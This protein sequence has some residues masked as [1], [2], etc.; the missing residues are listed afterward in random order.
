[1]LEPL[2]IRHLRYFLA[3]AESENFTRAAERLR[4][5]Q[6]NVSQHVAYLERLLG[7]PLLRRV[8]KRVQ[9]TEAGAAFRKGAEL[10]LRKL[11][12]ARESVRDVANA[13]TGHVE[14]GVIPALHVAWV[15]AVL[16]R[17]SRAYPGIT[18]AVRERASSD[19]E[20]ELEA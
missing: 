5:T 4:V 16:A 18:V 17:V 1:M 11:D 12:Q 13:V 14:L 8:G 15:P 10:V 6:P 2:E 3:V 20:T 7:T 19:L 9:L